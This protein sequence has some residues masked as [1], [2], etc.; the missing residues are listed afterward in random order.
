MISSM[1]NLLPPASDTKRRSMTMKTVKKHKR[2]KTRVVAI[3]YQTP[4]FTTKLNATREQSRKKNRSHPS[5][6]PCLESRPAAALLE[7]A[8]H[9]YRSNTRSGPGPLG[10]V[11]REVVTRPLM[12]GALSAALYPAP[13]V[14]GAALGGCLDLRGAVCSFLVSETRGTR[15]RRRRSRREPRGLG[16]VGRLA[17]HVRRR[18]RLVRHVRLNA[19]QDVVLDISSRLLV[20]QDLRLVRVG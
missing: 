13:A 16:C 6:H 10:S 7:V 12:A 5:S 1:S 2:R 18:L 3:P 14:E 4:Q 17:D 8:I 11:C 15:G 9:Q 20:V 19:C